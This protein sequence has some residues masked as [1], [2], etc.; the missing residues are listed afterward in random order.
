MAIDRAGGLQ[1]TGITPLDTSLDRGCS[2]W[3]MLLVSL[4]ANASLM[5]LAGPMS[6]AALE[7]QSHAARCR[8]GAGSVS[9]TSRCCSR[10]H[11]KFSA[12]DEPLRARAW[13]ACPHLNEVDLSTLLALALQ[14][15][16]KFR[17]RP[18][19][20]SQHSPTTPTET[21]G[22]LRV[23]KSMLQEWRQPDHRLGWDRPAV[24]S[25]AIGPLAALGGN[26]A[27]PR[28]N[29]LSWNR[30]RRASRAPSSQCEGMPAMKQPTAK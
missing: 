3:S 20:V 24:L 30:D 11:V 18:R 21:A 17:R 13:F 23:A 8:S 7:I 6:C 22:F 5:W 29:R 2:L 16:F 9:G 25:D 14:S 27:T 26:G 19:S 10:R 12:A 28:M 1:S 4:R 15:F